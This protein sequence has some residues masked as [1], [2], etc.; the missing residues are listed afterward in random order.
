LGLEVT[1]TH[2]VDLNYWPYERPNADV[3]HYG[4]GDDT[5]DKRHYFTS[6]QARNVWKPAVDAPRGTI[7]GEI[8]AQIREAAAFYIDPYA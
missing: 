2:T 6:S 1:L 4:Y 8:L 3:I 7:L 5:W